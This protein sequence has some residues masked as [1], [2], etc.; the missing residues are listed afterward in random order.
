MHGANSRYGYAQILPHIFWRYHNSLHFTHQNGRKYVF[1]SHRHNYRILL[2]SLNLFLSLNFWR[3]FYLVAQYCSNSI[4]VQIPCV[5][6][7]NHRRK[8]VI[9]C[10]D[11]TIWNSNRLY[12]MNLKTEL[13]YRQCLLRLIFVIIPPPLQRQNAWYI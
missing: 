13:I 3:D 4:S 6:N 12:V 5:H 9:L 11:S 10:T 8:H 7:C 1:C 2:Y